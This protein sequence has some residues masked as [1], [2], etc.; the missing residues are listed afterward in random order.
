MMMRGPEDDQ[1]RSKTRCLNNNLMYVHQI[2][3]RWQFQFS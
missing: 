2:K 3:L 1:D